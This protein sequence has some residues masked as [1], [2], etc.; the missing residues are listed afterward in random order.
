MTLTF[1][2]AVPPVPDPVTLRAD[3]MWTFGGKPNSRPSPHSLAFSGEDPSTS[4]V[5]AG[6]S[7]A[8]IGESALDTDRSASAKPTRKRRAAEDGT[9]DGTG[10]R[11][12]VHYCRMPVRTVIE[13]GTK[14]KR[15]VAF[16]LDWPGWSR[17]AKT[18]ELALQTLESYRARY[19][20]VATLAG[21]DPEFDDAGP[22][23]LVEDRV[24]TGS[25]DFWG[26]SFSPSSTEVDP[27]SE[28]EL[29]R[30][31]TLLRACWAFFDAVAARVSPE[32]RKGPR[33]GG[34]E[35][36]RIISHTIRNESES[37]AA[38]VGLRIPE[39]AAL[40]PGALEPYRD[41][42]VEAMRAYNAGEVEKRMR[43]WT[44]PFLIRHSAFHTLDHAWEME[45]K[46]LSGAS[47]ER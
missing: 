42:Y 18:A 16:S 11:R 36:D 15:S 1:E 26:I 44:L 22:L 28:A 30:K 23:V 32:M 10:V 6:R 43:S 17:G 37:F 3:R 19:R 41:A 31:L 5:R 20:P 24:G 13:H 8:R 33:G 47:S 38:Q 29:E 45:D 14:D 35:R 27:M 39:G 12:A 21:V 9:G 40:A 7:T 25:T 46:D 2:L 34:R 4:F